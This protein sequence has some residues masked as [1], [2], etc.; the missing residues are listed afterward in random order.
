MD[1]FIEKVLMKESSEVPKGGIVSKT[2][3]CVC[4]HL[5]FS[6]K[7]VAIKFVVLQSF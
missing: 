7:C 3:C 1:R 6:S 4:E 2:P 5:L